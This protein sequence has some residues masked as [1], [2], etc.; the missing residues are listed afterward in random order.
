[1]AAK[2]RKV[3]LVPWLLLALILCGARQ[4]LAHGTACYASTPVSPP[5]GFVWVAA[6]SAV[7]FVL[8]NTF[9]LALL[10]KVRWP[11]AAARAALATGVF[12]VTFFLFGH[13]VSRST[14]APPPGLGWGCRVQWGFAHVPYVR[15]IFARW[16]A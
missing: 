8:L 1:M 16:N 11:L 6:A 13:L 7:L 10:W 9:L 3:T 15:G 4:A 14:T 12:A 2:S 5:Q